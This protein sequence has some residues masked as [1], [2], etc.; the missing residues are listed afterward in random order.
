M[1]AEAGTLLPTP[2]DAC[3]NLRKEF[4]IGGYWNFKN[5]SECTAFGFRFISIRCQTLPGEEILQFS[6]QPLVCPNNDCLGA[7]PDSARRSR[8]LC[9]RR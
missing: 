8:R 5:A 3:G 6:R 4:A 9:G 1:G 7:S 2:L